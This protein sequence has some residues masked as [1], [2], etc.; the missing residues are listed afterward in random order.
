[1]KYLPIPTSI[2]FFFFSPP[3]ASGFCCRDNSW[4]WVAQSLAFRYRIRQVIGYRFLSF[5]WLIL[6]F[7]TNIRL[8]PIMRIGSIHPWYDVPDVFNRKTSAPQAGRSTG[9]LC[10]C[11]SVLCAVLWF[12]LYTV[13]WSQCLVPDSSAIIKTTTLERHF[14]LLWISQCWC[15]SETSFCPSWTHTH[16]HTAVLVSALCDSCTHPESQ[17]ILGHVQRQRHET[18]TPLVWSRPRCVSS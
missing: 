9:R 17:C 7:L 6:K 2:R 15:L 1:M 5:Q 4:W 11:V 10:L 14:L 16:T 3:A 12:I 18:K 13:C 8:V